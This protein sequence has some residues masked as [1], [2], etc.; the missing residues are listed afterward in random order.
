MNFFESLGRL[1]IPHLIE[2]W[3]TGDEKQQRSDSAKFLNDSE[4]GKE[5]KLNYWKKYYDIL[6]TKTIDWKYEDECR[7]IRYSTIGE[8]IQLANYDFD[9]LEG[10]IFGINTKTEHKIKIMEIIEEKCKKTSRKNFQFYQA[11][12]CPSEGVVKKRELI[13]LKFE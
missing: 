10:I 11:D 8:K 9:D 7:I 2:V 13:S 3:F 12:Y 1:P 6:N 5:W 4:N